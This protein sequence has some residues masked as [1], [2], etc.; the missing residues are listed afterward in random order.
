MTIQRKAIIQAESKYD[1]KLIEFQKTIELKENEKKMAAIEATMIY[2][3]EK[4]KVDTEFL[5]AFE[6]AEL[7]PALYTEKYLYFLASDA[8]SSNATFTIGEKV[9]NINLGGTSK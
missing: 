4:T 6:E 8:F 3:K 7:F 2:E 9:P 1:V 5:V